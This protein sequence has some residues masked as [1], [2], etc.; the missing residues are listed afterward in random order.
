MTDHSTPSSRS[1]S[2][3]KGTRPFSSWDH[4]LFSILV[5]NVRESL[6]LFLTQ[7]VILLHCLQGSLRQT[8]SWK[9]LYHFVSYRSGLA[10]RS[11]PGHDTSLPFCSIN[12]KISDQN[13]LSMFHLLHSWDQKVYPYLSIYRHR[14]NKRYWSEIFIIRKYKFTICII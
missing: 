6:P 9:E 5:S 7:F 8:R 11:R 10:S 2:R 4:S 14:F 13:S 12:S 3:N 1:R